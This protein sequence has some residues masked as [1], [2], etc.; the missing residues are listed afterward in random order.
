MNAPAARTSTSGRGRAGRRWPP[1]LALIAWMIAAAC[2]PAGS[3]AGRMTLELRWPGNA[4]GLH[5]VLRSNGTGLLGCFVDTIRVTV[6]RNG[7]EVATEACPYDEFGCVLDGIPAGSGYEV[8]AEALAGTDAAFAGSAGGLRVENDRTTTVAVDM[9]PIPPDVYA[10]ATITDLQA[11]FIGS[12]TVE[13]QWTAVGDDCLLGKV[14]QYKIWFSDDHITEQNLAQA[15]EVLGPQGASVVRWPEVETLELER[16]PAGTTVYFV[17]KAFDDEDDVN[18][19]AIS[20]EA[21]A[22]VE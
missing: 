4:G 18:Q 16:L 13:L 21:S 22:F 9:E 19:S 6:R 3:G 12:R 7:K 15:N 11:S 20:N 17:V 1:A 8:R 10:P 14:S 2:Q 5:T